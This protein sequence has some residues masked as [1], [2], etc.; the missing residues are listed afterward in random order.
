MSWIQGKHF[1][2]IFLTPCWHISPGIILS[3]LIL[4]TKQTIGE[5]PLVW[6]LFIINYSKGSEPLGMD[7]CIWLIFQELELGIHVKNKK[8]EI[9]HNNSML[10]FTLN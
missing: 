6:D 8:T 5:T 1:S 9:R 4:S 10:K 7:G 3:Q 2:P